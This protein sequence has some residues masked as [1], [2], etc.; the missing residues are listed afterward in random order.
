MKNLLIFSLL[1]FYVALAAGCGPKRPPGLPQLYECVLTIQ[2]EGGSPADGARVS[3]TP[4]NTAL[5][6][7]SIAGVT[8]SAGSVKI[9]TNADFSGAPAGKYRVLVQKVEYV[10][11][12]ARDEYGD[13]ITDVRYLVNEKYSAAAT[14]PLSLEITDKAVRETFTVEK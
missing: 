8:D 5:G 13:T 4:E 10:D 11:T 3:L 6:E 12:N 9:H 1:L 14:T 7:W 2:F